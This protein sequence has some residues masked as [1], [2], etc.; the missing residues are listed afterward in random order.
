[1]CAR[2]TRNRK[3]FTLIE[4]LVVIAIIAV[5]IGLLLPA[6]QKVREAAARTQCV[7]NLKQLGL[8]MHS[9]HD[10]NSQFPFEDGFAQMTPSSYLGWPLLIMPYI[11]QANE[12]NYIVANCGATVNPPNPGW[13]ASPTA[14]ELPGVEPIKTFICPSRRTTAVG[15]RIDYCGAYNGGIAEADATNYPTQLPGAN[16]Y[17]SILNTNGTSFPVITNN[18][19]SSNCLLLAH[20]ILKPQNY[21]GGS[22][23]DIGFVNTDKTDGNDQY[24]GY[25]HMRWCDTYAGDGLHAGYYQDSNNVDENHMGGPHPTASPVLY[26]DGH[27]SMYTYMYVDP[28]LGVSNDATWQ[29]AW[30]FNRSTN[31]TLP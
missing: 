13:F 8:A 11:E 15:A 20:K 16:S 17:R 26:A 6:I 9:F 10:A 21:F 31:L 24:G 27:V 25:D 1:M 4:L 12:Y 23:K 19:G 7:N 3:G 22:T 29:A 14:W 5:L 2:N 28:T 18:A 30:A